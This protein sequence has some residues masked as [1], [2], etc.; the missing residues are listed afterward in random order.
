M[1]R[2]RQGRTLRASGLTGWWLPD[3]TC[4]LTAGGG[5][6][7]RRALRK[8]N[9]RSAMTPSRA[10]PTRATFA[11]VAAVLVGCGGTTADPDKWLPDLDLDWH[12]G[13]IAL[14][15]E[16]RESAITANYPSQNEA[17]AKAIQT[18]GGSGC[19]TI[20]RFSGEGVCGALAH[21]PNN[22]FGVGTSAS[23][24][25]AQMQ[26]LGQCR[27]RGGVDCASGLSACND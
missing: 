16:T 20:L 2:V 4:G 6:S 14:N 1:R 13:S 24:D 7:R 9:A 17:D 11:L 5:R 8:V 23:L 3:G 26:A 12:F 15:A 27:A 18:C 22:A 25:A 10:G 21:A 19:T